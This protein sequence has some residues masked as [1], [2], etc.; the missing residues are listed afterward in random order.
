MELFSAIKTFEYLESLDLT[1]IKIRIHSDSQYLV[2]IIERKDKLEKNDFKTKKD[3]DIQN[4]DLVTKIINYLSIFDIEF[5]KV[6]AHVKKGET[7]NFNRKVDM[8]SRKI[9]RNRVKKIIEEK[10]I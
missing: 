9:V 8:L 2:R 1:N 3:S 6:I 7:E 5:I 10:N 4:K